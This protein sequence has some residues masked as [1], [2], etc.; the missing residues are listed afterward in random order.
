LV[1]EGILVDMQK[2]GRRCIECNK[3]LTTRHQIR[4]CS[5]KCQLNRRYTINISQWK[6]NNNDQRYLTKNISG[7][8]KR[9]L[10]EKC[11]EKCSECGWNKRNETSGKIPLEVDHIDGN[12][13]NNLEEN[14]RLLCP[15]C[16]AL[17][18]HFRNLNKGNGRAWRKEKIRQ[19]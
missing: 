5:N 3:I 4:Y 9:Y 12:S 10:I 16:H 7:Y 8:I 14:L 1:R 15:N 6:K 13:E 2:D 18:P 11:N 17:T 19:K